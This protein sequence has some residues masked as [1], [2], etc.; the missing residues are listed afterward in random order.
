MA[1]RLI[2]NGLLP[3]VQN[4]RFAFVLLGFA[5]TVPTLIFG[6]EPP[7]L[8]EQVRT[9]E[10]HTAAVHAVAFSPD[11]KAVA[12]AGFDRTVRLWDVFSGQE[13]AV[14]RG[15]GDAH[16]ASHDRT[17]GISSLVFF[18]DGKFLVVDPKGDV[19]YCS[20][21]VPG[22]ERGTYAFDPSTGTLTIINSLAVDTNNT[23]A[24]LSLVGFY[25]SGNVRIVFDASF[26]NL[27]IYGF[28]FVRIV[29]PLVPTT[30]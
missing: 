13:L 12:T 26:N 15:H 8:I 29:Y 24:G 1:T 17:P 30:E 21:L 25:L 4:H 23:C 22:V 9:L 11:G 3:S 14:L 20:T 10:G 2:L 28:P 16:P 18:P 27:T 6:A 19:G 7:L 5:L